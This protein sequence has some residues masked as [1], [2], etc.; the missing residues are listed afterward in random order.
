M[1]YVLLL[2]VLA[3]SEA[4]AD[5]NL[6]EFTDFNHTNQI[7]YDWTLYSIHQDNLKSP[8]GFNLNLNGMEYN[9][10]QFKVWIG[11]NNVQPFQTLPN[12]YNSS[13]YNI[14]I[15]FNNI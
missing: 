4:N 7:N 2:S 11:G 9:S 3:I 13:V 15:K 8:T 5:S 6:I 1:K 14:N 12:V 10:R